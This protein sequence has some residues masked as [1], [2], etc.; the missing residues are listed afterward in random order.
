MSIDPA[1]VVFGNRAEWRA[2]AERRPLF[3][4]RFENLKKALNCAYIRTLNDAGSLESMIFFTSRQAADDFMELM[5]VCGNSEGNAG[6]KLLRSF[7]E[8]VVT[9]VYL[10]KNPDK[11]DLYFNY[12]HVTAKKV[13]E[14]E[15]RVFGVDLYPHKKVTEVEANYARVKEDYRTREC[16]KCGRKEMGIA[17]SNVPLG[18]MAAAVD[19]DRYYY[20]AYVRPLLQSHPSVKGTLARFDGPEGGQIT[21]GERI[22][23]DQSDRVL[24]VAHLLLLHL[25]DVQIERF[26]VDGLQA[27]AETAAADWKDIWSR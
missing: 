16:K 15:H 19:L 25:F 13:M 4:E 23:R 1:S 9:I 12:Y 10:H 6:E 20:Y 8:R 2:F 14:A 22:D 24:M 3:L 17:W 27:L 7:Y 5:L 26:K 18:D 21:W 11:F